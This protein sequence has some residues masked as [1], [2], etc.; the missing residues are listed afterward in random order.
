M[1]LRQRGTTIPEVLTVT[2]IIGMLLS[3]MVVIVPLLTKS[4]LQMQAQVDEVNTAAIALYKIRRDFSE[5]DT[6]GIMGCTTAPVVACS[7]PPAPPLPPTSYAALVVP[8]AENAAGA[9]QIDTDGN[10]HWQGFYVYWLVP[11]ASGTSN[12]LMRAYVPQPI[13]T[14]GLST[15]DPSL[16]NVALVDATVTLAMATSPPPVL[17]NNIALMKVGEV[18]TTSTVDFQLV[19]GTT[20]GVDQTQTM[21]QSD[22]YARN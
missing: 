5:G 13:W 19:A 10:P 11:N 14:L 12:D 18:S 4:P 21:F 16:V 15:P 8:T 1:T 20:G 7:T 6:I 9:F 2:V 17:T 22:T 3:T